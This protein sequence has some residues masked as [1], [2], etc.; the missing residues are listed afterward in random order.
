MIILKEGF[1][2]NKILQFTICMIFADC[3]FLKM[4]ND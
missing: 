2:D 4:G 3:N 1:I